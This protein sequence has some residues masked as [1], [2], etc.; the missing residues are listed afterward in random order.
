MTEDNNKKRVLGG[1]PKKTAAP[2]KA[3]APRKKNNNNLASDADATSGQETVVARNGFYKDGAA[4]LAKTSIAS[5]VCLVAAIGVTFYSASQKENNVYFAAKSDG[6]LIKLIKLSEPNLSDAAVTNWL[7]RALIDTFDFNYNNVK[8]RLN[9]ATMKWFT[10]AGGEELLKALTTTGNIDSV[11]QTELFVNLTLDNAPLL[12]DRALED[13]GKVYA[14]KYQVPGVITYRTRSKVFTDKV[15]FSITVQRQS[16]IDNPDG[17]GIAK[18][19]M[20]V[21]R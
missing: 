3:E 15:V 8:P 19:I 18:I 10:P 12:V 2:V 17:L 9:D 13:G 16:M 1:G 14:W 11:I 20:L 4:I 6:S 21:K 7:S 5:V